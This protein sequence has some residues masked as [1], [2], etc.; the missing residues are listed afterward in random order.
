M[1]TNDQNQYGSS[2]AESYAPFIP[3][4]PKSSDAASFREPHP[5]TKTISTKNM[6]KQAIK[7]LA[8]NSRKGFS[9]ASIRK[10][11]LDNFL[12][13]ASDLKH[14][15]PFMKKIF[16]TALE[17]G[18]VV[19]VKGVGLNGSFRV[20]ATS[21][22]HK[23]AKKSKRNKEKQKRKATKKVGKRLKVKR[24]PALKPKTVKKAKRTFSAK[25]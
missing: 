12:H 1:N 22:L 7:A 8:Q 24:R 19:S 21:S 13:T 20:P 3:M 23:N 2:S 9:L 5:T 18:E 17:T 4:T 15:M 6:M 16:K 14:R 11:I 25:I 10:Y